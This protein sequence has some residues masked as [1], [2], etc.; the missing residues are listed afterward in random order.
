MKPIKFDQKELRIIIILMIINTFA[1]FVNYFELSPNNGDFFLLT[2]S[3]EFSVP[4]QNGYSTI[5]GRSLMYSQEHTK[6]FWPFV[7]Y[8]DEPRFRGIFTDYDHTEFLVYSLV[9]F[10][11]FIIRKI[12]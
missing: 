12:W 4:S 10:G 8:Y 1:L 2:D 9:I 3:K 6:H 5:N 11:F 7:K